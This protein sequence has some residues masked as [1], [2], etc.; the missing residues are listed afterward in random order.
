MG[1]GTIAPDLVGQGLIAARFMNNRIDSK[2]LPK[3]WSAEAT[4]LPAELRTACAGLVEGNLRVAADMLP[5]YD[6]FNNLGGYKDLSAIAKV[7]IDGLTGGQKDLEPTALRG[8]RLLDEGRQIAR[9]L[10]PGNAEAVFAESLNVLAVHKQLDVLQPVYDSEFF[11]KTLGSVVDNQLHM[12]G[13]GNAVIWDGLNPLA[14]NVLGTYV[15]PNDVLGGTALMSRSIGAFEPRMDFV[16]KIADTF[17]G[18]LNQIGTSKA[19]DFL[20]KLRLAPGSL[21]PAKPNA[22]S[23]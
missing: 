11:G 23:L 3:R 18:N 8:Y 2:S 15:N 17:V 5:I 14:P 10:M 13:A 21:Q 12:I 7:R 22:W 4:G 16:L 9:R 20:G 6:V 1:L 19:V